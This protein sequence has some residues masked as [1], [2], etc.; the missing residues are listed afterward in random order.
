M[1]QAANSQGGTCARQ[2]VPSVG[3][4]RV[5]PY[6]C[7]TAIDSARGLAAIRRRGLKGGARH[8]SS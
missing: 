4:G 2:V 7:A 5:L 3:T 1:T 8:V 6:A